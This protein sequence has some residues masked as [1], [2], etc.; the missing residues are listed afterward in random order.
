MTTLFSKKALT[1]NIGTTACHAWLRAGF[2]SG[3]RKV[4]GYV[5]IPGPERLKSGVFDEGTEKNG[6]KFQV[7]LAKKVI[8]YKIL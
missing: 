1:K 6:K 8:L 4:L 5:Y 3:V 7:L 2:L